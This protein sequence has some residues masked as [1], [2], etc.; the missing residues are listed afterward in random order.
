MKEN[1]IYYQTIKL[2]EN[3]RSGKENQNRNFFKKEIFI[4]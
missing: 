4:L 2:K 3:F 1:M